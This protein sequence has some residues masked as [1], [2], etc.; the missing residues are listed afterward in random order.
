MLILGI[1][2]S[3]KTGSVALRNESGICGVLTVSVDSTH[4]EGLMPAV[5]LLLDRINKTVNDITAVA[6]VK[7][8]GSYTGLRIGVATAQGIAFGRN[9]PGFTFTSMEVLSHSMPY[10][11]H[12]ICPIIP[13]RKGW[14]YTQI[15]SCAEGTPQPLTDE[16]YT[17]PD[18]LINHISQPTV[19][20][21]PGAPLFQQELKGMLQ[22]DCILL[23]KPFD[24]PRADFITELAYRELQQNNALKPHELQP[25]YLGK[26]Q[27]EINWRRLHPKQ[28]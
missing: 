4:S 28:S 21:G 19:F 18:E 6:G 23:S 16:L 8:P 9:I 24:L 1:D 27:A 11:R 3:T 5:D 13:A 14:M 10:C 7:G 15:F 2:T 20:F 17:N 25:H 26:S 12:P 22:D